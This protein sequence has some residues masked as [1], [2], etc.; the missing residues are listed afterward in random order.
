[1]NEGLKSK[2]TV[3]T[4][5]GGYGKTTALNQ[6]LQ[7]TGLAAVW[8]SLDAQDNDLLQ[9]WSYTLAAAGS[10]RPDLA[11]AV[12][13]YLSS[14]KSGA[15]ALFIT[16][17]LHELNASSDEMVI[18]FD[19]YHSIELASIHASVAY[20][21][22]HMP[23]HIHLYIASRAEMPFPA[24]RLQTT[25]QLVKLTVQ[26]LRFQLEEG[27]R[28]FQDCMGLSLSADQVAK[29]VN[30]TEG[31]ISGLHLAAISLR[32]GGNYSEFIRVFGGEHRSISDY[33]F[34]E[35][36]SL[37]SE[38]IQDFL[39][40]TAIL[41]RMNGPLCTAVTGQAGSQ[42]LLETLEHQNL[43]IIPLDDRREWY[44]YHH[45][46]SEFLRKLFR[47]SNTIRSKELHVRAARWLEEH[48]LID[49]AVE[50]LFGEGLHSEASI[51]LEKHL[52]SLHVK[53]GVLYRWLREL[54]ESCLA[55]KPGIQFLYVKVMVEYNEME[56]AE[57]R[58][59]FMEERLSEP[60]WKPYTENVFYVSALVSFYRR[61][62]RLADEYLEK[63]DRQTP[64]GSYIQMIEGNSYSI[65]YDTLLCFFNDLHEA[66]RFFY[67]WTNIWGARENYPAAGYQLVTYGLLLYEWNRLEEAEAYVERALESNC[68]Q[69][70]A[71]IQVRA[72][73]IAALI[74]QAKGD[75]AQALA[76]LDRVKLK[77]HSADKRIFMSMIEAEKAYLS[78]RNGSFDERW[79]QTCGI[80]S[81]DTIP[82][83]S[84]REYLHLA[85]ALTECGR[86]DE[87][88]RLLEQLYRIGDENDW[89]WDKVKISILQSVVMYRKGELMK[90]VEKLETALRLAEPG[91]YIRSFVDEGPPM[92][93]LL[94]E[95]LR[96]RK[97]NPTRKSAEV[98][99]RYVREL[100][101]TMTDHRKKRGSA[102]SL[103][104]KQELNILRMIEVGLSNKQ[105]ADEL[106][107]ST[108]TVKGHLKSTYRKLDVNNRVQA[109][110]QGKELK[111]L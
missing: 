48:G 72:A 109:L 102:D 86:V 80:Q 38:E 44:R 107:I 85:R 84:I 7:Q 62:F 103:L 20:F 54:P 47:Q 26:D 79:L 51:L 106:Q 70:Y 96:L 2:L 89:T 21:L 105:I 73:R 88:L 60:E 24:A 50:Q 78:L 15:F 37:Q 58:L 87:A 76:L 28:Y 59:R 11:D 100:L 95:Y 53:R 35:A 101:L 110:R 69:H 18:V 1:M 31:W 63:F 57:A 39:L 111:L 108:E 4:A 6:W 99:M 14:L 10:I 19:D 25:G 43:F 9:F 61:D 83:G 33:L 90:S 42:A 92:A 68:M 34:Q 71:I 27:I 56:L 5:P 98:S 16:A 8:V 94:R 91:R 97:L 81:T 30:R 77:I 41:D 55:E 46:F 65:N 32:K 75:W 40:K 49:E 12:S 23:A 52:R 36:F 29:L 74:C 66:E 22:A 17:M 67:K 45:L 3:I 13:P 104:T 93:E 64:E 82:L